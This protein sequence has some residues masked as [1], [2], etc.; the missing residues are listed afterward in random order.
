[1]NVHGTI[2]ELPRPDD[3]AGFAKIKPI[4]THNRMIY[5]FCSW[6]GM[7]VLSVR[8]ILRSERG[9]SF[10]L[11]TPISF[12]PGMTDLGKAFDWKRCA[13]GSKTMNY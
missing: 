8:C 1:M 12:I 6:R 7:L 11:A 5:N 2:Y 13:P 3:S 10:R 9:R 4:C